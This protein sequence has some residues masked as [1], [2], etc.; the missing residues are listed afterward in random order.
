MFDPAWIKKKNNLSSNGIKY[1]S[2][3]NKPMQDPSQKKIKVQKI[4]K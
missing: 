2:E 4:Q 1:K 3:Q